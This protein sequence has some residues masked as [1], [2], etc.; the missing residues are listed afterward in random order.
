MAH[1]GKAFPVLFRRDFN[2]NISNNNNGWKRRYLVSLTGLPAGP[3]G[4]INGFVFDCG[5]DSYPLVDRVSWQ[6]L[7]EQFGLLFFSIQLTADIVNNSYIRKVTI[8]A[9]FALVPILRARV[10]P[11]S[12][13]NLPFFPTA[14]IW[15]LEFYSTSFW[16]SPPTNVALTAFE[17]SWSDGPPH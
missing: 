11:V 16:T 4:L 6:S 14:G 12:N 7:F 3:G 9:G 10:D 1:K 8:Y 17:K 2:L 15:T 13:P 5:P